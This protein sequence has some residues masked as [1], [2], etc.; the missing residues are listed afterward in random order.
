MPFG[1]I[2]QPRAPKNPALSSTIAGGAIAARDRT[3]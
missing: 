2:N 1:D 3:P